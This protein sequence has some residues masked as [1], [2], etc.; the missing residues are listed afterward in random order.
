ML[1]IGVII[2]RHYNWILV[3]NV[4]VAKEFIYKCTKI[5]GRAELM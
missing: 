5:A 4:F 1:E 3:V 2:I